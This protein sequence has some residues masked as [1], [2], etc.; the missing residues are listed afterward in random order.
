MLGWACLRALGRGADKDGWGRWGKGE[1]REREEGGRRGV[2][3]YHISVTLCVLGVFI[4]GQ[5]KKRIP[6][7]NIYTYNWRQ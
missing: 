1:E 2:Y 4:A 7:V 6:Y 3:V 5:G